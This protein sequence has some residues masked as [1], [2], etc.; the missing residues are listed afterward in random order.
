MRGG[1]RGVLGIVLLVGLSWPGALARQRGDRPGEVRLVSLG[2]CLI[3]RELL[4]PLS[5]PSPSAWYP[6]VTPSQRAIS[7]PARANKSR[8]RPMN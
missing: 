5:P 8:V 7:K 1:I 6:R 4:A 3:T 2:N